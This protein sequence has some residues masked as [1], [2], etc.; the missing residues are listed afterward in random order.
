MP[1]RH[2][3]ERAL[4]DEHRPLRLAQLQVDIIGLTRSDVGRTFAAE[5]EIYLEPAV[6]HLGV[7]LA[8]GERIVLAVLLKGRREP[9][10]HP[11][12]VMLVNLRLHFIVAE[13]VDDTN[14]LS[15]RDA[16]P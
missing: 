4:G 3:V 8:H 7:H 11:V 6:F 12:D 14:L 9:L 1:A 5:H 16:L 2:A 13:V 15:R 10:V